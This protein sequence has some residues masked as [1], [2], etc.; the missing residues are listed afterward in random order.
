[1]D[2]LN[3]SYHI[4]SS[5]NVERFENIGDGIS[6]LKIQK[7]L[8]YAQ[9]TSLSVYGKPLFDESLE[10]WQYGPVVPKIYHHFKVF[11]SDNIDI[12]TLQDN[13]NTRKPIDEETSLVLDFVLDN[14]NQYSAGALVDITH[15]EKDWINSRTVN[16]N[17]QIVQKDMIDTKIKESFLSYKEELDKLSSLMI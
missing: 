6:N 13:I 5:I 16:W 7:L 4:L 17:N 2:A 11:G 15:R 10:A 12:I 9:K 8:Y 3:I 14:Y 1:M